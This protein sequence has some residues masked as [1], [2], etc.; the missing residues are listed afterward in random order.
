[1]KYTNV[2]SLIL[3]I[4]VT[5]FHIL[6]YISNDRDFLSSIIFLFRREA[7]NFSKPRLEMKLP[8][9]TPFIQVFLTASFT[10]ATT[11]KKQAFPSVPKEEA[12]TSFII[13]LDDS[14]TL[15]RCDRS[16]SAQVHISEIFEHCTFACR[17]CSH[18]GQAGAHEK[19]YFASSSQ[20]SKVPQ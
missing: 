1:M 20:T 8:V 19:H 7:K 18:L 10:I 3:N 12:G 4:C 2:G 5:F 17:S 6:P 13:D 15:S 9:A 14:C 16:C 11:V